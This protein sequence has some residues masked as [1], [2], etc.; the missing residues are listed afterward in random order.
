MKN[1]AFVLAFFLPFMALDAH[2][3]TAYLERSYVQGNLRVCVY[4]QGSK[5]ITVTLQKNQFC[6]V[7]L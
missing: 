6:P 5:Q 3:L 1:L 2:A 7:T 4:R